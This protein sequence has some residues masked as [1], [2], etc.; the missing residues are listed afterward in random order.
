MTS[1]APLVLLLLAQ[2]AARQV[3]AIAHIDSS[4]THRAGHKAAVSSH[5]MPVVDVHA[6]HDGVHF[7]RV[8]SAEPSDPMCLFTRPCRAR[9]TLTLRGQR[10]ERIRADDPEYTSHGYAAADSGA[11][12]IDAI[13]GDLSA[14]V[15]VRGGPVRLDRPGTVTYHLQYVCR[16]HFGLAAVPQQRTVVVY[17]GKGESKGGGGGDGG[18]DDTWWQARLRAVE[19]AAEA[20]AGVGADVQY[21][22]GSALRGSFQRP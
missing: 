20:E 4:T 17:G 1:F 7:K 14:H 18:G 10:I 15:E 16:N 6:T 5:S 19:G 3:A 22:G 13:D 12:C 11:Q 9:P 21:A 2:L 8:R